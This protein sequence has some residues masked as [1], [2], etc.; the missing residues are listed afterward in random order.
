[1]DR[2]PLL[3]LVRNIT[4]TLSYYDDWQ[5]AVQSH[6]ACETEIE[7][8]EPAENHTHIRAKIELPPRP[9]SGTYVRTPY[10][11]QNIVPR[12]F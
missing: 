4:R 11:D 5:D 12:L 8:I 6:P 7:D 2:L 9:E 10:G 1:M 3:V